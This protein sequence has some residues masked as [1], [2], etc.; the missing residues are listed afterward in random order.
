LSKICLRENLKIYHEENVHAYD[1]IFHTSRE[2]GNNAIPNSVMENN[3]MII[4]FLKPG[5]N[6][7][8]G[9]LP[10]NTCKAIFLKIPSD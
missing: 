7:Y 8:C 10:K 4:Y 2:K 5:G 3:K 1:Y 6:I 9:F